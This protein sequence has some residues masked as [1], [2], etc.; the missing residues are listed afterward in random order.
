V[1][2]VEVGLGGRL[3]CTNI[4]QPEFSLITNISYDHTQLLG[5]T[6]AQIA[7][8]KAG[9]IKAETP[10]IVGETTLE[11]RPVFLQK[12]QEVD[13]PLLFAE[14]KALTSEE[15]ELHDKLLDL[16]PL[17]G[18]YQA[19][20]LRTILAALPFLCA[21]F[22]KVKRTNIL[23]GAEN[24][25]KNTHLMGR[26]QKISDSPVTYCDTGHNPAGFQYISQQLK[27][28]HCQNLRIVLGMV[29]DKDIEQVLGML[30]KN[31]V[32]YF[33]QASVKRAESARSMA[34]RAKAHG[35]SGNVF[36]D[37]PS[38][39]QAACEEASPDDFIFI[40][41]STY[42][43]ADLMKYLQENNQKLP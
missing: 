27:N 21:S 25:I 24:V 15:L 11:T 36:D 4:I 16:L 12:A 7:S 23:R 33:T 31:A 8:E 13:A 10:V 5:S 41:G 37:V 29:S 6:L 34:K 43:V 19:K 17:K 26:W 28:Q 35:L 30:P 20:N 42:V 9:I 32:Y 38:A 22:P 14:E 40:G 18:L 2:V 3:D 39:Y 1:A